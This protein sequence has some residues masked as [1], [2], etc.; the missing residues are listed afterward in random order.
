MVN[1]YFREQEIIEWRVFELQMTCLDHVKCLN[2]HHKVNECIYDGMTV[3]LHH[4]ANHKM[5]LIENFKNN[6]QCM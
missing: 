1:M 2:R 6:I 3:A 4:N 5:N